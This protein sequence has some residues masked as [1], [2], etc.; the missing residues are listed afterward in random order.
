[1][2]ELK[3]L[4][5]K[6]IQKGDHYVVRHPSRFSSRER[7][8][9]RVSSLANSYQSSNRFDNWY[10]TLAE[11]AGYT[12]LNKKEMIAVGQKLGDEI[13][14]SQASKGT[15]K[16]SEI[17]K[18]FKEKDR[19]SEKEWKE[20]LINFYP[21]LQVFE[22]ELL[23]TK[24]FYENMFD[25][26]AQ[27]SS[28]GK[29]LGMAGTFD[30]FGKV[31]GTKLSFEK[32]GS[33]I[34]QG[35][36]HAIVDWKHPRSIKYPMK[37]YYDVTTYP[38]IAYGVQ[39]ACYAAAINQLT[40]NQWGVNRAIVDVAPEFAKKDVKCKTNYPYYFSPQAIN[41]FWQNVKKM[42]VALGM[43]KKNSF[44]YKQFEE[45]TF[46]QGFHG[47]RLYFIK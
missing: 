42:L 13:K 21:F 26:K 23:E 2:P 22:P 4:Q 18:Y 44:D 11:Q 5:N 43:N 35:K 37:K 45:E 30:A 34:A 3:S 47:T 8:Y 31:D 12:N 46:E 29:L 28:S 38:L 33:A 24:V 19:H 41:W 27:V 39:L 7:K 40:N 36:F 32:N 17:E 10:I 14:D 9:F 6:I 25:E 16:H 20:K 1:M 15:K